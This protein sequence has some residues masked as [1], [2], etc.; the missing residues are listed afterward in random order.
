MSDPELEAPVVIIG[1]GEMGKIFAQ[2][3][4]SLG[5]PVVPAIRGTDLVILG[6][7]L[8]NRNLF[9]RMVLAA[10][11]EERLDRARYYAPHY[12]MNRMAFVQNELLPRDL[13]GYFSQP[14]VMSV[15]FEKKKDRPLKVIQP[16]PVHGPHAQLLHDAL[17][18]L[19]IP[20]RV[21]D[22]ADEMLFEQVVKNLYILTTNI[23][24][25]QVGG[26][27][28]TLWSQ[29][30]EL[31]RAVADDVITL[32]EALTGEQFDR[33]ALLDAMLQAFDNDPTHQCMGRSAPARLQRALAN[34]AQYEVTLP[35]LAE[36]AAAQPVSDG[37]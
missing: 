1:M 18:T 3:L 22:S 30:R 6:E 8:Y 34:A 16:S 5:V 36:I 20:S 37:A 26:D 9:P 32:Q 17:A 7:H 13:F 25:L 24:G 10:L 4:L 15:W 2:G 11:P 14:T 12:W 29:H 35:R 33:G 19:G 21:L 28:A 27:V 31:A 23:A